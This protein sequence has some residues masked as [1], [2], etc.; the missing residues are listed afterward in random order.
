MMSAFACNPGVAGSAGIALDAAS[1]LRDPLGPH[2][3]PLCAR[4]ARGAATNLT[5]MAAKP[6]A[7]APAPAP[8]VLVL[9]HLNMNHEA[10]RHDLVR[11]FYFDALGCAPDPRKADNLQRGSDTLWANAGMHQ[12]HLSEGASTQVFDGVITLAYPD[13][14]AVR[15]RLAAPPP[16][17]RGTAFA[18]HDA[19]PAALSVTDPWGTRFHLVADPAARDPRGRQPGAAADPC[20]LADL[21]VHVPRA[22]PLD[23]VARFYTRV[24]GC[25]PAP[26]AAHGAVSLYT[27]SARQ[28]LTFAHR[29]DDGGA[30][31]APVAH[32]DLSY[33][34]DGRSAN[35]GVH[36][37]LY[38][39]DLPRAYAAVEALG[40]VYVNHRFKRRAETLEQ[41][42]EQSMFRVLDVVDPDAPEAGPLF[43]LEHE[44]RSAIAADGLKYKSCP[45]DEV[46]QVPWAPVC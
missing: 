30:P 1:S 26:A 33:D 46:P 29:E 10:G 43:R 45:L 4:R 37:S 40:G 6:R 41:A 3:R 5:S 12:F 27:G 42:V 9:D 34:A 17:L 14:S 25:A 32:E 35:A 24:L 21:R 20:A 39:A 7:P 15:A 22:A 23:A 28:T 31:V 44:V 8:N 16:A 13:L 38:V 19:A 36:L 18:V 2:P 11:A